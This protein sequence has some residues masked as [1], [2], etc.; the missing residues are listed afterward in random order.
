[1][2]KSKTLILPETEIQLI[3]DIAEYTHD[4]LGF[5]N[6]VYDWGEG[7]FKDYDGAKDWQAEFFE[8]IRDKLSNPETRHQPIRI[9]TSSGHGIGKAMPLN[10]VVD[11]PN[12]QNIWVY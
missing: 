11:T 12:G 2:A 1:M 8:T 4:P 9:A 6:Y 5:V 3:E 7:L 10:I